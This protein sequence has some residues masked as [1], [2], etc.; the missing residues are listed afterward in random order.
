MAQ[1]I[2]QLQSVTDN[3]G[4]LELMVIDHASFASPVRIVNDTRDWVIGGHTYVALPF[5][6]KLPTQAQQE[7]PRAQIRID[8]VGRELTAAIEGLP[9]G[10]SLLATLQLVSRATPTVVDYEF[11]AQL[12]GINITPTL[13]TANMG[14]DD[15]MR[16]TAVRIRFDPTNAP[17]LFQG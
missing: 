5:G 13:V 3:H 1:S 7:N 10:A 8:N 11:I 17:A 6:V 15:T 16:Q 9:V 14:P 4:F 2:A 12:S